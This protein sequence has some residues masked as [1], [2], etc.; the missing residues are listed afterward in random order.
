MRG[1]RGR[2]SLESELKGHRWDGVAGK[3]DSSSMIA[4]T[5]FSLKK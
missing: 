4:T 5:K 1:L 2:P 3:W